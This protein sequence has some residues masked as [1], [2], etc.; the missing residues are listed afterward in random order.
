LRMEA[1][2]PLAESCSLVI[3]AACHPAPDEVN[4]H[5]AKVQWGVVDRMLVEGHEH[6]SLSSKPIQAPEVGNIY[7]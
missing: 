2:L 7:M 6:C 4:P 1:K 5:L 3:S